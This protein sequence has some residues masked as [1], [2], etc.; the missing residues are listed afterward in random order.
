ME[1]VEM[2]ASH[3]QGLFNISDILLLAVSLYYLYLLE[4]HLLLRC[5]FMIKEVGVTDYTVNPK[6][7]IL[8]TKHISNT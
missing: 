7:D 1:Y 2:K 3:P 5:I 4:N 8:W 6:D